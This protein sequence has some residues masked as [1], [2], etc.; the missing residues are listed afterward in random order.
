[1]KENIFW[2]KFFLKKSSGKILSLKKFREISL[3]NF[4]KRFGRN[5]SG[6]GNPEDFDPKSFVIH[7]LIGPGPISKSILLVANQ[8]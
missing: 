1:L 6:S 4:L 2:L 8:K 3:K 7:P 5:F